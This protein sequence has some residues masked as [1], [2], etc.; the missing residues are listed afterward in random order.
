MNSV[1]WK[2]VSQQTNQ[3]KWIAS[4]RRTLAVVSLSPG[5]PVIA[6]RQP[7]TVHY[8]LVQSS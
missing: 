8:Y 1:F 3:G 7:E 5:M 2:G 6:E 4:K